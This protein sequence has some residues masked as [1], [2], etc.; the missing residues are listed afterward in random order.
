MSP[1]LVLVARPAVCALALGSLMAIGSPAQAA[2]CTSGVPG[3]VNGDG[4]AEVAV[5]ELGDGGVAGAVHLF[6]GSPDG[7]VVNATGTAL[8]DQ[9]FTQA[10][11]GVPGDS[12]P[13][14][15][16]GATNVLADFNGDGCAD[17]AVGAPGNNG[18]RG[19]LTVL[20]GDTDGIGTTGAQVF[21]E[22]SIFGAGSGLAGESFGADLMNGDYD[23]DGIADLVVA[24]PG[25]TVG[26]VKNAGAVVVL[27]GASGGLGTG[28]RAEKRITQSSAGVGGSP[29]KDDQFGSSLAAGDFSGDGVEDVAVG[30][31]GEN[32]FTG[33]VQLLRGSASGGLNALAGSTYSQDTAGVAGVGEAFDE[34][35]FMVAAGD[36]T[37]DGRAD[38]AVTSYGEDDY[39]GAVNLLKGSTGGLTGTG[40]QKWTQDSPGVEGAA[41]AGDGFGFSLSMARLD[42]GPLADLAIGTPFDNLGSVKNAGSVTV[43]LGTGSGLST[44]GPGGARFTQD[45]A[46]IAGTAEKDDAFGFAIESARVVTSDQDSLTIGVPF[47]DIGADQDVGVVHSLATNEFGPNPFGSVTL[48]LDTP[49]VKGTP[50]DGSLFAIEVS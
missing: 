43:L 3:D 17:L 26:G 6:Y 22:N 5:S 7:I 33:I 14:D 2:P 50:E 27:Y 29:E 32:G 41:A 38:L 36:V 23:D 18:D 40:S 1:R 42:N 15:G 49:G 39:T 47:E 20:Y 28:S 19:S 9:L 24:A 16:F 30:V 21:S 48:H 45:T 34:F 46:G 8:D 13:E 37:G 12:N 4:N 35:G 44:S 11:P 10:T 31:P 25:E